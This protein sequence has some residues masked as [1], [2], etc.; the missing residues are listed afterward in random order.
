VVVAGASAG[1][2]A[3]VTCAPVT[4]ESSGSGVGLVARVVAA[5]RF[6]GAGGLRWLASS[7]WRL[8][9][10]EPTGTTK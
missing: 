2:G 1:A 6:G 3:A 9:N 10:T 4:M 8:G 5:G 7:A